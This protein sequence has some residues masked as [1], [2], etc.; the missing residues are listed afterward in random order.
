MT[1]C[2]RYLLVGFLAAILCGCAHLPPSGARLGPLDAVRIAK[3]A[4]KRDGRALGHY[5]K[6]D[7][8]YYRDDCSWFV[9]FE[10]RGLLRK[11]GDHFAVLIDDR[12]GVARVI[13]GM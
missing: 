12:T 9:S 10:G 8:D 3:E 13:G 4:A 6:P 5:R 7:T 2:S 11:A 1:P